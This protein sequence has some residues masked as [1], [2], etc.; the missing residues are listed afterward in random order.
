MSKEQTMKSHILRKLTTS[1]IIAALLVSCGTPSERDLPEPEQLKVET[2]QQT[3]E[4]VYDE[5]ARGWETEA[6]PMG[7]GFIGAMLYGGVNSDRIQINEHTLWSG[8][9]GASPDYYGG[10]SSASAEENRKNLK[11]VRTKLQELM[12]DFTENHSAK[13]SVGELVTENYPNLSPDI[14]NAINSLKGEKTNYGSYQSLG[15]IVINDIAENHVSITDNGHTVNAQETSERLF[16][17]CS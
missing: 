9:P 1:I 16:G 4:L 17:R 13:M 2:Q 15:E 10:M 12:T 3:L 14:M 7:N 8:G 11:Y 5:P 6:L